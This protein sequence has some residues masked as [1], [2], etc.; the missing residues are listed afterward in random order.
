MN[1]ID[2]SKRLLFI[3]FYHFQQTYV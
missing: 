1:I 2:R 3:I